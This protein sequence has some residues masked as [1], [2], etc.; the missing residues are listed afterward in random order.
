MNDNQLV[1]SGISGRYPEAANFEI[2]WDKLI[3][4]VPL[5]S[6]DDRRWPVGELI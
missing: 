5:Y 2:L 3:Q 1:I 6:S 4:G